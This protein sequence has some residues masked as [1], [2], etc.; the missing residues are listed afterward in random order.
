MS[1][2]PRRSVRSIA[3]A[4][5][6]GA[7][8]NACSF[9]QMAADLVADSLTGGRDVYAS[10]SDPELVYA[11]L[12]FGLKIFEG[13]IESSPRNRKLLLASAKGFAAYAFLTKEK[14]DRETAGDPKEARRLRARASKLFLR[15]RDFALRALETSHPGI[16]ARLRRNP[17][18][19]LAETNNADVA[20]LYLA[21][22]S[23]GG[24]VSTGMNNV[25]LIGELPLAA[26]LVRR[27]LTLDEAYDKG[28][29]HEFFVA[30]EGG[31]LAGSI[32][33]ARMHYRR[34][35]EL[36]GGARASV[37]ITLAE[38]IAAPQ[39]DLPEFRRLLEAAKNIDPQANPELRLVNTISA[40]RARWLETQV[41][42][43]FLETSFVEKKR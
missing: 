24:A 10:D 37:H 41:P 40:D 14:A 35:Q 18:A 25:D 15:A 29:A 42:E 3:V 21:G 30:Y 12:P 36:S 32:E 43:L 27:V 1:S 26:T 33:K 22:A 6:L 34:A 11:A 23:W 8:V 4:T 39:Q 17:A 28:A 9:Q 13:L 20:A 19:A 7:A 31:R 16:S 5:V 38:T 2:T